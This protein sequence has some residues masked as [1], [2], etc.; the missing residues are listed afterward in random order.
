MVLRAQ[1][2]MLFLCT[3]FVVLLAFLMISAPV[4]VSAAATGTMDIGGQTDVDLAANNNGTGWTW[5]AATDTLTLTSDYQPENHIRFY[6]QS[7]DTINVVFD[8]NVSITPESAHAIACEG[9]LTING[10][11]GG[12]LNLTVSGKINPI[13]SVGDCFIGS[14]NLVLTA[15]AMTSIYTGQSLII[16]G[17]ATIY[18]ESWTL[19]I[20]SEGNITISDSA[21]VAVE[22]TGTIPD[23]GLASNGGIVIDTTGIVKVQGYNAAALRAQNGSSIE[24]RNGTV[25][26]EILNNSGTHSPA[27]ADGSIT[28]TGGTINLGDN[29]PSI[30]SL[31]PASGSIS[32]GETVELFGANLTDT[33]SVRIG[34]VEASIN[35]ASSDKISFT[36]PAGTAGTKDVFVLTPD[37]AVTK[38]NAYTYYGDI[39]LTV[40]ITPANGATNVAINT[41][42]LVLTFSEKMD[43]SVAGSITMG[44]DKITGGADNYDSTTGDWSQW[45]TVLTIPL[46]TLAY[47]TTYTIGISGFQDLATNPVDVVSSHSFTTSMLGTNTGGGGG[48]SS[49]SNA[50]LSPAT[51]GFDLN[52]EG[53]SH[54]DISVTLSRGSYTFSGVMLDGQK[55]VEGED[56]TVSDTKYTFAKEFLAALGEGQHKITFDMSGGTDPV[57]TITVTNSTEIQPEPEP[58]PERWN[59]PFID[60]N[61]SDWFYADV[62][63]VHENQLMA[64]TATNRFSPDLD[65]TRGM[66]VTVLWRMAGEP[67]PAYDSTF[68]DLSQDYYRKAVAWASEKGIASGYG[69]GQFGPEDSITREDLATMLY[70]YAQQAG[71]DVSA[72]TD[73][74]GYTDT[75]S[76]SPYAL[77]A[78]Q[79]AN[80]LGLITGRTDADLAPLGTATRAE[81]AA[82]L[83]RYL[84]R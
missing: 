24:V 28:I 30:T 32:G 47:G 52:E 48:G 3:S 7:T 62:R 34:G 54:T 13:N 38:S 58:E 40:A 18:T 79:W 70:R 71:Y 63:Y 35:V 68:T 83:H 53:G 4:Y 17:D 8:G 23:H 26:L 82:I 51:A 15:D 66:F 36:T 41:G 6:C 29:P 31:L 65:V 27:S 45:D 64:G 10:S 2:R 76:I 75:G 1:K 78:M 12:T 69:D 42:T 44:E 50:S 5:I 80:A 81:L 84:E 11:S 9:N 25:E 43:T 74:S 72:R 33:T 77:E 49:S 37:G 20:F 22:L 55:L 67:E 61:E 21:S 39:S 14:G 60:V 56:Y 46:D 73:L 57:L 19:G 59:N 16:S